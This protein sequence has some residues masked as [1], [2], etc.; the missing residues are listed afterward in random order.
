V[1]FG[2]E[3]A[4]GGGARPM[5]ALNTKKVAPKGGR[6]G[7]PSSSKTSGPPSKRGGPPSPEAPYASKPVS[8]Q[9]PLLLAEEARSNEVQTGANGQTIMATGNHVTVVHDANLSTDKV[10]IRWTRPACVA[11][12]FVAGMMLAFSCGYFYREHQE[13]DHKI[14]ISTMEAMLLDQG[15]DVVNF[16]AVLLRP[17]WQYLTHIE[18]DQETCADGLI[19]GGPVPS[20]LNLLK[21][22][23][24]LMWTFIG[25]AV[26]SDLFMMAIEQIT[27]TDVVRKIVN[28]QGRTKTVTTRLWNPTIANLSLMALGSSAPEIL[29][30]VIEIAGSGFYAGELGPSTIVG[31]AAFNMLVIS[32]VCV[33]AIP[34]GQGRLIKERGVFYVTATFS[35][36]AYVWLIIILNLHTPNVVGVGEGI[37]TFILFPVLLYLAYQADQGNLKLPAWCCASKK[38]SARGR[39][40]TILADGGGAGARAA[41]KSKAY[42]RIN[43]TRE[44]TGAMSIEKSQAAVGNVAT[45]MLLEAQ[46]PTL[47]FGA[48]MVAVRENDTFAK[49]IVQ[50]TGNLKVSTSAG[51]K[52]SNSRASVGAA[53]GDQD[54]I[55]FAANQ[56]MA[57]IQVDLLEDDKI[58]KEGGGPA[59]YVTLHPMGGAKLG[60]KT[61]CAVRAVRDDSA[62][63][64]VLE[65]D[66]I[67]VNENSRKACLTLKRVDGSKGRVSCTVNT[68]DGSAVSPAD[69]LPVV[70]EELIF[71]DGVLER[72]VE[73]T[74]ISDDQYEGDE[75]FG[76][77][78]SSAKGGA[79]FSL[80]CDGG[81][82]QA[83][84]TVTIIGDQ[85]TEFCP[86]SCTEL[87]VR[88]GVNV[89]ASTMAAA[90]YAT[91]FEEALQMEEEGGCV[92][93]VMFLLSVPWKLAC[94]FAPPPIIFG[95]WPC[96]FCVLALIGCLTA[97][98]GDFATHLG[99][100]MG[101]PNSITAIT[102]VA[103]GTSLP[104]TFAS[105]T[106]AK[107]EDTADA[108]I[109][110]VTGSN[111]VNVFLGL[112]LPWGVAAIYWTY[113]ASDEASWRARYAGEAWYTPEM[114]VSFIM[115]AGDLGFSVAVFTFCACMCLAT[116]ML[117]RAVIGYELG[118]SMRGPTAVLFVLLWF[119]Y[120]ALSIWYTNR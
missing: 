21:F 30:S 39:K 6:S 32:A 110:N 75:T 101:I 92:G 44:M 64:F 1:V 49:V 99:C 77:I 54:I 86:K 119:T 68:Q 116:L 38:A 31:S 14:K 5:E 111:S 3:C 47:E 12:M 94:A 37:A 42:Y 72:S 53:E 115:P 93:L 62:G 113:V 33:M 8:D 91:Q 114:P 48:A 51:Y 90:T 18:P 73:I 97:V 66:S 13:P 120:I 117:R 35:V 46:V 89:D 81:P 57:T 50:R 43:A 20:K 26:F 7:P 78:F 65:E 82:A 80:D 58:P 84:A 60:T 100:C 70:D 52:F 10:T 59:F 25:V 27:S 69:Y 15:A 87:A 102:F 9:E 23:A 96:F 107:E 98:I 55:E 40:S 16:T 83:L 105:M 109:G 17:E 19:I 2:L 11:S 4:A 41:V 24:L 95:G 67:Y 118:M 103:L 74:I 45:V 88:L 106:A 71:E 112:G 29:L 76:V 34:D 63:I 104:D 108:S 56:E 85:P 79:T 61:R 22:F 36:F 28:D